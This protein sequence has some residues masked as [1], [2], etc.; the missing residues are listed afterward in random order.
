M[1]VDFKFEPKQRVLI[2][3]CGLNCEGRV[4]RAFVNISGMIF[5]DVRYALNG[6]I[7]EGDF[8]EDD[9]TPFGPQSVV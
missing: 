5:Y 4:M 3:A 2:T 9:L 1:I 8:L 6:E 7:K